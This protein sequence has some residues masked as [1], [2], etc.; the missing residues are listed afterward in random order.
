[1]KDAVHIKINHGE[2][3]RKYTLVFDLNQHLSQSLLSISAVMQM[4]QFDYVFI[5]K[6]IN[7]ASGVPS[8]CISSYN[9]N[10]MTHI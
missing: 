4:M 7:D 6:L 5:V 2:A 1:M 10:L 3:L 8:T 9:L